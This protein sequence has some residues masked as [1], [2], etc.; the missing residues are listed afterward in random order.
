MP[1]FPKVGSTNGTLQWELV[2]RYKSSSFS[3]VIFDDIDGDHDEEYLMRGRIMVPFG[4]SGTGGFYIKPNG[5]A[6][7][8]FKEVEHV[9]SSGGAHTQNA[10]NTRSTAY[11]GYKDTGTGLSQDFEARIYAKT[12]NVRIFSS[13]YCSRTTEWLMRLQ[14]ITSVWLNTTDNITKLELIQGSN[15]RPFGGIIGLFRKKNIS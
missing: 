13:E 3:T 5:N 9:V 10:V 1:T 14:H 4:G 7:N 8:D 2:K 11:I 12:G 6:T 15:A